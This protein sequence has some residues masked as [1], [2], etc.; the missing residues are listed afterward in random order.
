MLVLARKKGGVI[1]VGDDVRITVT[2]IRGNEV[3]LG[4]E[5][6]SGVNIVREEIVLREKW[7]DREKRIREAGA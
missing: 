2:G 7:R 4:I 3:R 6:P 5:A 1:L